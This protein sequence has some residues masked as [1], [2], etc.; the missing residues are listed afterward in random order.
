M[1][2]G[3]RTGDGRRAASGVAAPRIAFFIQHFPP[4]LGG[5]EKQAELLASHL[6]ASGQMVEVVSTRYRRDLELK[7]FDDGVRIWRLPTVSPRWVKLPLNFI[8]GFYSGLVVARR[9]DVFHMHCLSAFCFGAF[10]AAKFF[11]RPVLIKIC[12]IGEEGDVSKIRGFGPGSLLWRIFRTADLLISPT[13]LVTSELVRE[14]ALAR[15]VTVIPNMLESHGGVVPAG[16]RLALRR[17]LGMEDRVTLLYVGRLHAGKGLSH[18]MRVWPELSRKYGAQL[19]L[20]GDGPEREAIE[21]WRDQHGFSSSVR[22][23]GYKA[24]PSPY[25][26]ASDIFVFPSRSET[27]GNVIVEAMS[28]GLAVATTSVGVV[29]DWGDEAPVVHI[30]TEIPADLTENIGMLIE[31]EH[32]RCRI[33]EMAEKFVAERY[34]MPSIASHYRLCYAQLLGC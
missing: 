4:Y 24:D 9:V 13:T 25:Y 26:R 10:L 20:V 30:D 28:H 17:A 1:N 11:Q 29:R 14:G 27:F 23:T 31:E 5:A 16:E 33:G 19:V 32:Y 22:L 34:S 12:A 15:R 8:T 6:A 7:S 21:Q 3:G 2:N 18:L